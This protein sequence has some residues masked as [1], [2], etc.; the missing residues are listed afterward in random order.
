MPTPLTDA[1]QT[2]TLA[3]IPRRPAAPEMPPPPPPEAVLESRLA[4]IAQMR[5][6]AAQQPDAVASNFAPWAKSTRG[7]PTKT[8][9]AAK[10]RAMVA[11][12]APEPPVF[13]V[14]VDEQ[15]LEALKTA[16]G[17]LAGRIKATTKD[18]PI[19]ALF[20]AAMVGDDPFLRAIRVRR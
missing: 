5:R 20:G 9:A 12:A 4:A 13:T 18:N 16:L 15:K 11:E 6:P 3:T 2:H 17:I 1:T 19:A 7:E 8:P 14:P 10:P